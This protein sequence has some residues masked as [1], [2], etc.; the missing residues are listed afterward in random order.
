MNMLDG[1]D[2]SYHRI[3]AHS[4]GFQ[5]AMV[6]G[7]MFCLSKRCVLPTGR[8]R[9]PLI[10]FS[11]WGQISHPI[12]LGVCFFHSGRNGNDFSQVGRI[13]SKLG[14]TEFLQCAIAVRTGKKNKMDRKVISVFL[15]VRKA[16]LW[17]K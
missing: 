3:D 10:L 7:N 4:P 6:Q 1:I 14:E 9:N 5:M 8:N 16:L 15:T 11:N 2:K 12:S 13:R 17:E